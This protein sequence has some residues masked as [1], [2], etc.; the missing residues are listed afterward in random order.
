MMS[1]LLSMATIKGIVDPNYTFTSYYG[2]LESNLWTQ[3]SVI[4]DM[5]LSTYSSYSLALA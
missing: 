3:E 2:K 4:Y 1:G 5:S